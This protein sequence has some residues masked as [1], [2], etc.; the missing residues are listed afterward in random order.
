[1]KR[2]TLSLG[3][4]SLAILVFVAAVAAAGPRSQAR[5]AAPAT[6]TAIADVLGLS[7]AEIAE[8]RQG[9]L[10][11]AQIAERQQVDPEQL[12]EAF[13]ARWTERIEARVQNGALSADQATELR[14][15]LEL[16]ARAMVEQLPTGGMRGAAVGAGPDN[17]ARTGMGAG[18]H[19]S[20]GNGP[21][22]GQAGRG[23]G[24]CDGSGPNGATGS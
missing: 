18:N 17:A 19:A 5:N 8:L 24:S 16:K 9:G 21:G 6:G 12:I 14:A 3:I 22:R 15:Q 20:D 23:N 10:T 2:L 11:L 4:A 1:M 13:V 7:Q